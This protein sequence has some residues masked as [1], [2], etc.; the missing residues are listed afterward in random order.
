M[1]VPK[2]DGPRAYRQELILDRK[3]DLEQLTIR[4]YFDEPLSDD[5]IALA[6]DEIKRRARLDVSTREVVAEQPPVQPEPQG[7]IMTRVGFTGDIDQARAMQLAKEDARELEAL[8]MEQQA[9]AAEAFALAMDAAGEADRYAARAA[10]QVRAANEAGADEERRNAL[11]TEAARE[12]QRAREATLRARAAY[13]AGSALSTAA[14]ATRQRSL[15]AAKLS[16]DLNSATAAKN[17]EAVLQQLRTL[18]ARLDEKAR[19]DAS[20]EPVEQARQR[21]AE[22]EKE[23][24][25]LLSVARSKRDEENEVADRIAR[26]KRERDDARS[27]S[28]QDELARQI[29]ELERQLVF[30]RQETQAAVNKAAAAER[31]TAALRGQASLTRHLTQSTDRGAGTELTAEQAERLGLRISATDQRAAE[32]PI[33]DRFDALVIAERERT[34]QRVFDWDLVSAAQAIGEQREATRTMERDAQGVDR[35]ATRQGNLQQG[36]DAGKELHAA[37]QKDGGA[38]RMA[39]D[40]SMAPGAVDAA[41]AGR[42]SDGSQAGAVAATRPAASTQPAASTANRNE[43]PTR[44]GSEPAPADRRFVLENQRAE[45]VQLAASERNR[46]RKDSL[47][48]SIAAIDAELAKADAPAPE[49]EEAAPEAD[50]S[51]PVLVFAPTAPADEIIA[52]LYRGHA[53]DLERAKRLSDAD[54]R[55]DAINGIELM[56]ADSIRAEMQR[57]VAVLQLSPQQAEAVLPRVDRLRRL[58]EERLALG[59]Q[60]LLDRQA[61]LGAALAEAPGDATAAERPAG[62]PDPIN[63]R[64]VSIDRYATNV[65]ASTVNHRSRAKGMEEA[66]AFRDADVARIDALTSRI[67]SME[68]QLAGM[69]FNKESDRLRKKTDQL[70]DERYIIRTDLGQRSAFLTREEWRSATD[71]LKRLDAKVAARGLAPNEPLVQMAK[72]FE[73][74]ARNGFDSAAQ[75]RKRAERIEDIVMRD[76]LYRRAYRNELE[77]LRLMDRAITVRNHLAGDQH[78]RGERLAYEEVASK[79]LGIALEQPLMAQANAAQKAS[80]PPVEAIGNA[81]SQ[82]QDPT[83]GG[84]EVAVTRDATGAEPIARQ[85]DQV[86][87]RTDERQPAASN[88]SAPSS[89]A[90]ESAV[91][92]SAAGSQAGQS[93]AGAPVQPPVQG[94]TP[95]ALIAQAEQ[96]LSAKDLVPANMYERFLVSEPASIAPMAMDPGTDP[97]LLAIRSESAQRAAQDLEKRSQQ[98][99]DRAAALADSLATA[100]KRDRE[101]IEALAARERRLSDSLHLASLAKAEEARGEELRRLDAEAARKQRERLI[102]YYYLTPEEQDLVSLD[103]D[104]SRYFQARARALEQQEAADEAAAAAKSNRDVAALMRQQSRTAEQAATDGRMPAAEAVQRSGALDA[105]AKTLELRADSLDRVADRLRSASSLNEAQAGVMLQALPADRSSELMAME[106]RARR[107]DAMAA[108]QRAQGNQPLAQVR[109]ERPVQQP[110]SAQQPAATQATVPP[111][112]RPAAPATASTALPATQAASDRRA[113]ESGITDQP[114]T[115]QPA[116]AGTFRMPDELVEDVFSLNVPGTR[117]AEA[118]PM[119]ATLPSGIVFKVQIGA[120][121]KPLPQEAFSDMSP[122]MGETV[123]NG[124]VRYTAGLFTTADGALAAK[125]L[126]RQRGYGDAFVVAYKDGDRVPLGTAMREA[127]EQQRAAGGAPREADATAQRQP[128]AQAAQQPAVTIT[129]PVPAASPAADEDAAAILARYPASAEQLMAA[130]A[131]SAEATAYYNVPGAAP[132]SQVEA[133]KGLFFTVQVGVYSRPVPL[134]KLFNITPLNSEL[135]ETAKVRYTTGRYRDLDAVRIRKDVAVRLGVKDAFITA[136]LNGKRIPVRE[137]TAL[138][139]RFGP[140]ILA[141]P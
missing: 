84:A 105:R 19:P 110:V 83:E 131:P 38:E 125:E 31:Q 85:Q 100:R 75:L 124:L 12:R 53:S 15:A 94:A 86:V 96:R 114:A 1:E 111:A 87:A 95:E 57:Q 40:P 120:F 127:R 43:P 136:Y 30:L 98:A 6:L 129:R 88:A 8:S 72:G 7:D 112:T 68:K 109:I 69:P 25:R 9:Q 115:T 13:G 3:G 119:D 103:G 102:K 39:D 24:A 133:I 134:D 117:R 27:R 62:A 23:S 107:A 33:D 61:E 58:R 46:A 82:P 66:I 42:S 21:L 47:N 11:M 101:R 4:N 65:F 74:E 36:G 49:P 113:G 50:M 104:A 29:T 106:Q 55:A 60:A 54:A 108:Q 56:L 20:R 14:M 18:K 63:D 99:A 121:R 59:E 130:F 81:R 139:E 122:V 91:R 51:R 76:S 2:A 10:E 26:L 35:T 5:L 32:L 116:L 70:I 17:D 16:A 45:L 137:A 123:G 132:A 34:E 92:P 37:S 118:I 48:R 41:K 28:K 128:Q 22:Q 138:L 71:S 93:A 67:D 140:A 77:A 90:R 52:Q 73:L 135:T 126:V 97:D 44:P 89:T 79:V 141:Q 78:Q 80:A 64:F